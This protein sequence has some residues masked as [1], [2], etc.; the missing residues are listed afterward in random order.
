MQEVL[1][2]L[3]VHGH[4]GEMVKMVAHKLNVFTSFTYNVQVKAVIGVCID[5][6]NMVGIVVDAGLVNRAQ[7]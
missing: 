6:T 4:Q 3:N 2:I 7:I 1:C 5:P